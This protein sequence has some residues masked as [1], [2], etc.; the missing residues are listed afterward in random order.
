MA[1][2][3]SRV[4]LQKFSTKCCSFAIQ[5]N[6]TVASVAVLVMDPNG[7]VGP[8][9]EPI[10]AEGSLL[11]AAF[12]GTL[13]GMLIFGFLGDAV[14]RHLAMVLT[15]ATTVIAILACV[16]ITEI[17]EAYFG[18]KTKQNVDEIYMVIAITRF[19]VGFG[20]G[21]CFVL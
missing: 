9:P 11:S 16:F 10:W 17:I 13:M 19:L 8:Y 7:P 1:P 15:Q 2:E 20:V 21:R 4:R 3:I 5:Y 6:L 12:L 18:G 14:G